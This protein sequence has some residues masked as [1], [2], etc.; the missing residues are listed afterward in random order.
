VYAKIFEI[1]KYKNDPNYE[2]NIKSLPP[3]GSFDISLVTAI[4]KDRHANPSINHN[5]LVAGDAMGN[6]MV[7]DLN[8]KMRVLKREVGNGKR[9]KMI[10][11]ASG[12]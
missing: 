4:G 1:E 2:G 11:I 8:K 10:S 5:H 6:I 3:Q 7:L 12:E 9:V